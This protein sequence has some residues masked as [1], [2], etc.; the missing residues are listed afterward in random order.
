MVNIPALLFLFIVQFLLISVGL[1]VFF[2]RKNNALS[3][4]TVLSHGEIRRLE[5]EIEEKDTEIAEFVNLKKVF[6]E[7]Q[8]NFEQVRSV[9][10]KLKEMVDALVPEAER[11]KEMQELLMQMEQNN[12]N[13]DTCLGTM[14]K[15]NVALS[16]RLKSSEREAEKLSTKMKDMVKKEDY[17]RVMSEKKNLELKIEKLRDDLDKKTKECEKLEKNYIYL[18]KEYN[19][20]YKNIKGEDPS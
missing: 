19:A 13:L 6:G 4:K 10:T 8:G 16:D 3:A 7:L 17:Q 5:A 12:K 18:E 2:F 1:A 11:S 9:N 14:Q 15:E 20:L